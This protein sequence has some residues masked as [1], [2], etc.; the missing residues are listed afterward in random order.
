MTLEEEFLIGVAG[1]GI[2]FI[3]VIIGVILTTKNK[4]KE[5]GIKITNVDDKKQCNTPSVSI[6]E[7]LKV[8]DK[9]DVGYGCITELKEIKYDPYAMVDLYWFYN[10]KG[11]YKFNVREYITKL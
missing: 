5:R 2:L 1:A 6:S 10:E 11:E 8:G 7:D 9:I 3:L 4:E